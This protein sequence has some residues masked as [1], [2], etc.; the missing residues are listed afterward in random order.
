MKQSLRI[1][2]QGSKYP[3]TRHDDDKHG[4][5]QLG[6]KAQGHFINLRCGLKDTD[7]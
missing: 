3:W 1:H 6:N 4:D 2:N 7:Q 5:Q